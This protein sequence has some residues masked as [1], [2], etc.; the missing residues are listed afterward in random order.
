M[1]TEKQTIY[2]SGITGYIAQHITL[3]LLKLGKFKVIGS[4]RNEEKAKILAKNFNNNSDLSFD[5][6]TDIAASDAF[7]NSFKKYGESL[8]FII[9]TASPFTFE[10]KDV[11]KDLIDPAKI[12]S[13][14]I[15]KA[16]VKYAPNL[17]HFVVTS[18]FAAIVNRA[19]ASNPK[20]VFNEDSWNPFTLADGLQNP[21]N[22]YTYSKT[23]AEKTIWKLADSLKV[24]FGVSAVNPVLVLGPQAFDSNVSSKLNTSCE[25]VNKY[26]HSKLGDEVPKGFSG[27]AVD[28]RD[29]AKAHVAPLLDSQKFNKKRLFMTD[30]N[31]SNQ[32][33]VDILNTLPELRGKI[34]V[35][36]PH[37]DDSIAKKSAKL[38][39]TKTRSLLDFDFIEIEKSVRD[40]ALQILKVE[41]KL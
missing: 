14:N 16:A 41:G 23:I 24:K 10:V 40:T 33:F 6:V 12:G 13:E 37:K 4:V 2:I 29:V 15:F 27:A 5:Y 18:S 26:V 19:T 28:V 8:D 38:D 30:K 7:E 36:T 39:N 1:S 3:E 25:F 34:A 9:H 17:K 31:F 21:G 32:I 22:G 11:Q 20:T 35:G